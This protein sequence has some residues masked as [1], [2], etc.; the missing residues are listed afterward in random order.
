MALFVPWVTCVTLSHFSAGRAIPSLVTL[1]RDAVWLWTA[2]R[3]RPCRVAATRHRVCAYP[4]LDTPTRDAVRLWTALGPRPCRVAVANSQ[5]CSVWGTW[6][7]LRWASV[8]MEPGASISGNGVQLT[9]STR[10]GSCCGSHY[11]M[12]RPWFSRPRR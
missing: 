12:Q 6:G 7:Q 8:V 5:V 11:Q 2:L 1:T 3:F 9:T 10:A 4:C